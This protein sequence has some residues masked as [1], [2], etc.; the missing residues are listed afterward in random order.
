MLILLQRCNELDLACFKPRYL[1]VQ[2]RRAAGRNSYTAAAGAVPQR[3]GVD[4]TITILSRLLRKWSPED[5]EDALLDDLRVQTWLKRPVIQEPFFQEAARLA[6]Q[7]RW[8]DAKCALDRLGGSF[9]RDAVRYELLTLVQSKLREEAERTAR[10][11]AIQGVHDAIPQ[12]V[13]AE[14]SARIDALH[15]GYPN[16]SELP[17]LR[18]KLL[19][20]KLAWRSQLY[21]EALEAQG[22][23]DWQHLSDF[24]ARILKVFPDDPDARELLVANQAHFQRIRWR[25]RFERDAHDW[26]IATRTVLKRALRL[27]LFR[28]TAYQAVAEARL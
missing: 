26:L 4:A 18:N 20:R 16:L 17:A 14:A 5:E 22:R 12:G 24:I 8:Y 11:A 6:D 21:A 27:L 28:S 3:P 23:H 9:R 25:H 7:Q 19:E 15:R 13:W 10:D 2:R 1:G